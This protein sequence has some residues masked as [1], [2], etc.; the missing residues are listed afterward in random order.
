MSLVIQR[1][2]KFSALYYIS[3]LYILIF[4]ARDKNKFPPFEI[5]IYIYL[6][7]LRYLSKL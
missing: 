3:Y 4:Y 7:L 6:I 1:K 2:C 5:K